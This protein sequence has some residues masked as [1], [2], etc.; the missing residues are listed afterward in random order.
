MEDLFDRYV[1][2]RE[3]YVGWRSNYL[4]EEYKDERG[5]Q[6]AYIYLYAFLQ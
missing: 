2:D 3:Q 1:G 6:T 5:L 4:Y